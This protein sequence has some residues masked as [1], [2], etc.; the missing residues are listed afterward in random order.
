VTVGVHAV[1]G[2]DQWQQGAAGSSDTYLCDTAVC[3]VLHWRESQSNEVAVCCWRRQV[4]QETRPVPR[5]QHLCS[6]VLVWND[7]WYWWAGGLYV[8]H[9]VSGRQPTWHF[10][11]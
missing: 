8:L 10:P 6:F 2:G 9:A 3:H 5:R 4:T 11:L 1:W 7:S